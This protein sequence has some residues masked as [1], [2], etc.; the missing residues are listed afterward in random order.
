MDYQ[1]PAERALALVR[2]RMA[3][4]GNLDPSALF[5]FGSPGAVRAATEALCRVVAGSR[6][7]LSSGCDIPPGTPRENLQAWHPGPGI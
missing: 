6:W 7:I 5:R 4:R 3:L 2:G 1:V